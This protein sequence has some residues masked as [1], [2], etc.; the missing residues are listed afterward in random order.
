VLSWNTFLGSSSTDYGEGIAVDSSGN[1]Y[2][3]GRSNATWGAPVSSYSD[4]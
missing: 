4:I 3:T 2:V 1:V